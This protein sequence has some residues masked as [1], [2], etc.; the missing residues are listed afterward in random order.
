M[1]HACV[2]EKMS[3]ASKREAKLEEDQAYSLLGIFGVNMPLH[4]GESLLKAFF[5]LQIEILRISDDDST[6]AWTHDSPEQGN[7]G[8]LATSPAQFQHAG[9]FEQDVLDIDRSPYLITE[10]NKTLFIEPLIKKYPAV[11]IQF[12]WR[13]SIASA[14]LMGGF[15]AFRW[16]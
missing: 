4:Y 1:E 8:A 14:G 7:K 3:W 12:S 9:D 5:R 10:T 2:A 11:Q 16:I 13:S 15:L 6:F